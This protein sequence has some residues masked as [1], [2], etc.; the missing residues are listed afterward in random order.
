[1]ILQ[2]VEQPGGM[3]W[4]EVKDFLDHMRETCMADRQRFKE[5]SRRYRAA[6]ETVARWD[7]RSAKEQGGIGV[8]EYAQKVLGFDGGGDA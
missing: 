5:E 6:L 1:M 2:P 7:S 8:R 4:Q 3:T